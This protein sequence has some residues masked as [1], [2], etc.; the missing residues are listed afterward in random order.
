MSI[1]N[2]VAQVAAI[3]LILELMVV[4]LVFLGVAG[5]LAFGLRWVNGK[6]DNAF[7]MVHD[8]SR[9]AAGYVHTGTGYVALPVIKVRRSAETAGA[10]AEAIK[11]RVRRTEAARSRETAALEAVPVGEPPVGAR[12]VSSP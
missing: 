8:Y 4:L 11:Q 12:P 6:S 2:H 10:T 7:K 9:K 1:L 3:I 5:G